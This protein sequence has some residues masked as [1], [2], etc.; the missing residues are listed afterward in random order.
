MG[1]KKDSI[2]NSS[3]EAFLKLL[4]L[5]LT[6]G[7]SV[8]ASFID[9]NSCYVTILV[10]AVNNLYD[11]YKTTDNTLY[12]KVVKRESIAVCIFAVISIIYAIVALIGTYSWMSKMIAKL[13]GVFFVSIPFIFIVYDYHL[14]IIKENE[15]EK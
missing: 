14:N 11:F 13:I 10:Q 1:N 4:M 9:K 7:I 8:L 12:E 5:F 6:L 15:V 2:Y 3:R